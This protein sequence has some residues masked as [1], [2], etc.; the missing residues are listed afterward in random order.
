MNQYLQDIY[1]Q[2][3]P[4]KCKPGCF[5]CCGITN[6][7]PI[8]TRN[9]AVWL[10]ERGRP[11]LMYVLYSPEQLLTL[12]CPYCTLG[13]C[14]IYE[15]RPL[16]CRIFGVTDQKLLKCDDCQTIVKQSAQKSKELFQKILELDYISSM[17]YAF[18]K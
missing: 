16:I 2:V 4:G 12:T 13:N 3:P 7:L 15:V 5:A 10:A 11:L 14:T 18:V 8:E 9:I 17:D 1:N 6:W